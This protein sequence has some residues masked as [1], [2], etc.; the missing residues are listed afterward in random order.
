LLLP[1]AAAK[2][3]E[4]RESKV[5]FFLLL[6]PEAGMRILFCSGVVAGGRD[7]ETNSR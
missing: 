6:F 7:E 4:N 3:G 1:E 5:E 2:G